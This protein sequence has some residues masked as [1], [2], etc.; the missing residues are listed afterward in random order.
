MTRLSVL[1]R[2]ALLVLAFFLVGS[3]FA[4]G[5]ES[6]WWRWPVSI[7]LVLLSG[8]IVGAVVLVTASQSQDRSEDG[9][10]DRDDA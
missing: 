1:E 3:A 5:P 2:V 4:F 10:E 9:E 6:G 7:A 8:A